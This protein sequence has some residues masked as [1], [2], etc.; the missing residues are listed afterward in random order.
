MTGAIPHTPATDLG[1][2]SDMNATDDWERVLPAERARLVRLCLRLTGSAEWAEDLA[3]ETLYEA[4]RSA[5]QLRDPARRAQWLSGIARN[6]CR[7][8]LNR[9]GRDA[10]H[11]SPLARPPTFDD[12]H[13]APVLPEEV[14][15]SDFDVE[16]ELERAELIRLLDRAM[17]LLTPDARR[18][19][20]E[21]YVAESPQVETALRLGLSEGAV[22]MKLQRGK[23]A[24]RRVLSRE[25]RA[26]ASAYGLV[27]L[28]DDGWKETSLWCSLCGRRRLLGRWTEAQ[29]FLSLHCP[30]CDT[31]AGDHPTYSTHCN[32]PPP[33]LRYRGAGARSFKP[34]FERMREWYERY[35][36]RLVDGAMPC[37]GCGEMVPISTDRPGNMLFRPH[38]SGS[39]MYRRCT[40]CG[41]TSHSSL[42]ATVLD[43][44]EGRRFNRE[45]PRVRTLPERQLEVDGRP[46]LLTAFESVTDGAV[47]EALTD[48]GTLRTTIVRGAAP[49]A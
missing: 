23:L 36:S 44:S 41:S 18:V 26:E 38:C 29:T 24:L 6:V 43:S 22:A 14:L 42:A 37:Y 47:F 9:R 15:A 34:A 25:L 35:W 11:L 2:I 1:T 10:A 49:A 3:Q 17:G 27:L 31:S 39:S 8:W 45:H 40:R 7:Q 48:R 21:R 13:S 16:L 12:P 33:L 46:V 28:G 32:L 19:L 5:H 20:Y 4:H 30:K